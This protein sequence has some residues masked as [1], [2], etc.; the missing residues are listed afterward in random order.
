MRK[1]T[2]EKRQI[3]GKK[4]SEKCRPKWTG[5]FEI[6]KE[7]RTKKHLNSQHDVFASIH[8][9]V[10]CVCEWCSPSRKHAVRRQTCTHSFTKACCCAY[11]YI[12]AGF[13]WKK[14]ISRMCNTDPYVNVV[15]QPIQKEPI[16]CCNKMCILY[17]PRNMAN[18]LKYVLF[19]PTSVYEMH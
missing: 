2:S 17:G 1:F 8:C 16:R 3:N 9:V 14:S 19:S 4:E 11:Q 10:F 6:K 5:F 13:E 7:Q 18:K 15:V 12:L